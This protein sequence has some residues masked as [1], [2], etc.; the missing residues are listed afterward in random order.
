MGEFGR[1]EMHLLFVLFNKEIMQKHCHKIWT[2]LVW[3]AQFPMS[4][5]D[6]LGW[7]PAF[8]SQEQRSIDCI[9]QIARSF[10]NNDIKNSRCIAIPVHLVPDYTELQEL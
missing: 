4:Q 6:V 1:N 2:E 8:H 10:M 9:M 5:V 3:A 7:V